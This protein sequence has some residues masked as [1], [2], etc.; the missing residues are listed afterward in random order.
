[1]LSAHPHGGWLPMQSWFPMV[2][3]LLPKERCKKE[4]AYDIK[5]MPLMCKTMSLG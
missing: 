2:R 5:N 4:Y 3:H 1:M